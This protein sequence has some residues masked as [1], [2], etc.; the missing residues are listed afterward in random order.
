MAGVEKIIE[1]IVKDSE[2][3]AAEIISSA[4]AQAAEIIKKANAVAADKV[5]ELKRKAEHEINDKNRIFNSMAE[6]EVRNEI[7][8]TKQDIIAKA[9]NEALNKLG[10]MDI[11]QYKEMFKSM[12]IKA[13]ETGEEEILLSPK[14]K[15][16]IPKSFIDEVNSILQQNGKRGALRLSDETINISGGFLLR[17]SGVEI[18]NSFEA[19]IRMHRDEIEPK[20]AELLF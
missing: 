18:N 8:N 20:V 11:N 16:R 17:S 3:K 13:V 1:K 19:L 5:E 12:I 10:S 4:N 2:V 9:F 7:L 15:D 6:L 14:D